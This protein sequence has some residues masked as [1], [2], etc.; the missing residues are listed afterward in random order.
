MDFI[1]L[2]TAL[3]VGL[4]AGAFLVHQLKRTDSSP[5]D[6]L[7]FRIQELEQ[8]LET[9]KKA[10]SEERTNYKTASLRL[11]DVQQE[12]NQLKQDLHQSQEN[13]SAFREKVAELKMENQHLVEKLSAQKQDLES[14]QERLKNEFRVLATSILEENSEKF[15]KQNQTQV[16]QLLEPL[17][18]ELKTFKERIE[19]THE[20]NLKQQSELKGKLEELHTLNQ[21][22]TKEA[23]NLTVALKGDTKKQGDWG[24]VILE[25]ILEKS[26]LSKGREY[27]MQETHRNEENQLLRPDVVVKLPEERIIVI[28]SKV[29]LT[30]YQNAVSAENEVERAQH[31]KS[32]LS[33]IRTHVKSL[34]EK[35]YPA[36]YQGKSPDFT[37]MFMPIQPAFDLA[38]QND[39]TLYEEAF[40]KNIVIVSPTTLLA[41]LAIVKQVWKQENQNQNTQEIARQ[42]AGLLDKFY[43]LLEDLEKLGKQF[44]TAQNTYVASMSKLQTGKGNLIKRTKDIKDLGVSTKKNLPPAF[45]ILQLDSDVEE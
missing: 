30:A 27:D 2:I 9:E 32:H 20:T 22:I 43:G 1:Q 31:I 3:I 23:H 34:S 28:D 21:Q 7:S 4:A 17:N 11:I 16:H 42:S 44:E 24:E 6:Q 29:S 15:S 37:L 40:S 38:L 12:R 8:Q 39:N 41:T 19:S 45:D 35:N 33:S 25:R 10:L 14:I 13:G 18:K 26:G 5:V 36:L